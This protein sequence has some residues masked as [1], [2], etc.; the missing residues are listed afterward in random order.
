MT[1]ITDH[2][3][4]VSAKVVPSGVQGVIR[5]DIGDPEDLIL[6]FID[7]TKTRRQGPGGGHLGLAR[8]RA[9]PRSSRPT[10]PIGEVTQRLDRRAGGEPAGPPAAL[11]RPRQPRPRPGP[12]R[13]A[14]NGDRHPEDLRP[15]RR[16]RDRRR[17]AAALL[18]LAGRA[19]PHQPRRAA[20]AGRLARPARRQHDRRG[21]RLLDRPARRLPAGRG[22]RRRPRWSCSAPATS[23]ASSASASRSTARWC[24]RCSAWG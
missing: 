9:S 7:S 5:P 6:D 13:G 16:D 1:L 11:R 2:A 15:P 4:A 3:S 8:R 22:A 24:R 12:D 18:L 14:A 19:L 23:P 10:C 17:A 20:G 21:R